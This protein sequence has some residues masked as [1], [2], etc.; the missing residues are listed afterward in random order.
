MTGKATGIGV[1]FLSC[2][3]LSAVLRIAAAVFGVRAM[4]QA[5]VILVD[6]SLAA[7]VFLMIPNLP[8]LRPRRRLHGAIDGVLHRGASGLWCDGPDNR[9]I[10]PRSRFRDCP[11]SSDPRP[12]ERHLR[13]SG[14]YMV[15]R[16]SKRLSTLGH[17]LGAP[18]SKKMKLTKPAL[19][20]I[21][22]SSQLI[23]VSGRPN[24]ATQ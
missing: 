10:H 2:L 11:G 17:P 24:Q 12:R 6:L 13:T 4:P 22:R 3:T 7:L 18:P 21:P 5:L 14:S 1:A 9:R 16:M 15:Q 23:L 8:R 19:A 20:R